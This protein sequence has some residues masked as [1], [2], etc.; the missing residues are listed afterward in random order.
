[1]T[2]ITP[3]VNRLWMIHSALPITVLDCFAVLSEASEYGK[4]RLSQFLYSHGFS[5]PITA[6]WHQRTLGT[7]RF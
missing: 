6:N 5:K 2:D 7:S 3:A 4:S 1:M